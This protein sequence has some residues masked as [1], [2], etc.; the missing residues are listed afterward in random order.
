MAR[1]DTP[2]EVANTACCGLGD[3]IYQEL[4]RGM[5]LYN[6]DQPETLI[7]HRRQFSWH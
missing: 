3:R 2:W 6:L 4:S 7:Y 5:N 1:K